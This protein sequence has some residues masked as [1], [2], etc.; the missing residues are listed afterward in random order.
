[1]P[2]LRICLGLR[3]FQKEIEGLLEDFKDV[4]DSKLAKEG[5]NVKPMG[6]EMVSGW[7]PTHMQSLRKYTPAVAAAIRQELDE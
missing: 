4:F 5:A 2:K 7:S 6:I 1:L 3:A